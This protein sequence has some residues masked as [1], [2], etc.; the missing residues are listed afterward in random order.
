MTRIEDVQ[1][2]VSCGQFPPYSFSPVSHFELVTVSLG[3]I[4]DSQEI[5]EETQVVKQR[6]SYVSGF[7]PFTL[8]YITGSINSSIY[9]KQISHMIE[10]G[11]VHGLFESIVAEQE[12]L[13]RRDRDI[14]PFSDP[15]AFD[16]P[17][18]RIPFGFPQNFTAF[19]DGVGVHE[20][21]ERMDEI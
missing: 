20:E 16:N 5:N 18:E 7:R 10:R 13:F 12:A 2:L 14:K 19:F 4:T 17:L 6:R 11:G 8:K 9:V 21:Q 1:I 15:S 3:R